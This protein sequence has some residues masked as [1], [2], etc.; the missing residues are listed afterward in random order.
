MGRSIKMNKR[1][2]KKIVKN[3]S[4]T[5]RAR[6]DKPAKVRTAGRIDYGEAKYRKALRIVLRKMDRELEERAPG[7]IERLAELNRQ[8]N[9]ARLQ[10]LIARKS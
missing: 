2:A 6:L 1:Q 4:I 8:R 5:C 9:T 3:Q 7:A 10:M